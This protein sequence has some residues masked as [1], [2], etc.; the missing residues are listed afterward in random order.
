MLQ[1]FLSALTTPKEQPSAPKAA[2]QLQQ[3]L[4]ERCEA[5][6]HQAE[7]RLKRK[8]PRP[9]ISFA[10]RGK[11]A[12]TAHLQQ[13]RLRFNPVLLKENPEAFLQ[14]VVP[15]EIAHLLCFQLY[16]AG[17][18]IKPHGKEWQAIMLQVFDLTPRASHSFDISSVRGKTYAYQCQCG[19]V[20]LSVRR[21]N[22]VQRGESRY[23][24]RHCKQV[25]S[26]AK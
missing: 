4:L 20:E 15:H 25:L 18:A 2:T 7:Q 26:P 21:H 10:L 1:R 13:N 8:F 17:K 22:K 24:C 16:G 5:C 14:E 6:F 9:A 19:P 3:Q 23:L 12:G 11:S